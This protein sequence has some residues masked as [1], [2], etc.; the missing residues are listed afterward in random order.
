MIASSPSGATVRSQSTEITPAPAAP[1]PLL[2]LSSLEL[3]CVRVGLAWR[4]NQSHCCPVEGKRW[5]SNFSSKLAKQMENINQN[6][7]RLTSGTSNSLQENDLFYH[8]V[9]TWR[10]RLNEMKKTFEK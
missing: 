9:A 5:P 8:H 3:V 7:S 6:V 1:S 4:G 10:C 2:L